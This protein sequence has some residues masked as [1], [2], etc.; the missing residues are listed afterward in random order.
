MEGEN[1]LGNGKIV[2]K[3]GTC[4]M[5]AVGYSLYVVTSGGDPCD[6]TLECLLALVVDGLV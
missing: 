1:A 4:N 6:C 5:L 2:A 3:Y